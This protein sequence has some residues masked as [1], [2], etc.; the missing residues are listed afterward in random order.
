M[1]AH[2]QNSKDLDR[3]PPGSATKKSF[4]GPSSLDQD[5]LPRREAFSNSQSQATNMPL[6][7]HGP[8]VIAPP[9]SPSVDQSVP[10]QMLP[11]APQKD[12]SRQSEVI[13]TQAASQ[14]SN[15]TPEALMSTDNL[16]RSAAPMKPPAKRKPR[17][18]P[19]TA[20][21]LS[22][23][24]TTK[25]Y[26]DLGYDIQ[27]A[28]RGGPSIETS[29]S[30]TSPLQRLQGAKLQAKAGISEALS[31]D[32]SKPL[33]TSDIVRVANVGN[34]RAP[35]T[36][37]GLSPAN[38]VSHHDS[39]VTTL[40]SATQSH[41][42]PSTAADPSAQPRKTKGLV[43]LRPGRQAMTQIA[44]NSIE[45]CQAADDPSS[46]SI[47]S[48]SKYPLLAGP[49]EVSPEEFMSQLSHFVH[50]SRHV[51]APKPRTASS[52]ELAA[53]AAQPD[54]VR[55]ALIKDMIYEFLG[56]ENFIKLAEDVSQ[57]WTRIGLGF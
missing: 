8:S 24:K 55:Q 42:L 40:D 29:E 23:T 43:V 21:K 2:A 48:A 56:D 19:K 14:L 22:S 26:Q 5:A 18:K 47:D 45:N 15:N 32:T 31:K 17:A 57:E 49:S 12:P 6:F 35:I 34:S 16:E 37:P 11:L 54:S 50:D 38:V 1:Q 44:G 30:A 9:L 36:Q 3:K 46:A 7:N 41:S 51:P 28:V 20:K 10:S 52:H 33:P 27:G 53:Y 39:D 4:L 25:P 13:S